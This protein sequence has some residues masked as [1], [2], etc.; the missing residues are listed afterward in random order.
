MGGLG[1]GF[2]GGGPG[3]ARY[4][5]SEPDVPEAPTMTAPAG[6]ATWELSPLMALPPVLVVR[7]QKGLRVTG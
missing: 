2:G 7:K 6:G 5:P 1:G 3:S 4:M